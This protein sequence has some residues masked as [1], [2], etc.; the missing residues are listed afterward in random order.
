MGQFE[1][2]GCVSYLKIGLTPSLPHSPFPLPRKWVPQP[3]SLF[4]PVCFL[5]KDTFY[6]DTTHIQYQGETLPLIP[7]FH[8]LL[9]NFYIYFND[10]WAEDAPAEYCDRM[11]RVSNCILCS[12]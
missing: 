4:E 9:H 5:S 12:I 10:V 1:F 8:L 11:Q 2:I 7:A 6:V 3:F